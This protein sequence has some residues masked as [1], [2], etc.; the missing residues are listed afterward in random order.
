MALVL[1]QTA[2][3]QPQPALPHL[4]GQRASRGQE[5]GAAAALHVPRSQRLNGPGLRSGASDRIEDE[6][7]AQP[8]EQQDNPAEKEN[9]RL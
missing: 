2:A 1:W 9:E 8:R 7:H 4:G 3:Q 6:H 5:L